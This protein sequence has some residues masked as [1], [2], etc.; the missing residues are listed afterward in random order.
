MSKCLYCHERKGKRPCPALHGAICSQCCGTHRV[1]RIACHS[2]CVYLDTNVA[3]QQQ[4]VGDLFEQER[5]TFYKELL[6]TGGDGA[7]AVFYFLEA[8][9]FKHFQARSDAQDGE[10]MAALQALRRSLSP[11]HVPEGM[12][13]PFTET[14][15]KEYQAFMKGEKHDTQLVSQVLD[16]GLTFIADFSG[17]GLRSNRFLTGLIGFLK[18][19]HPDVAAQLTKLGST[20]GRIILP[21]GATDPTVPSPRG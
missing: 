11:I 2:D 16:R 1:V 15:K 3:Y 7:A 9:T 10:V 4:R 14:L 20:E 8:V 13:P 17:N 21:S 18:S 5:R 12:A 19:R 6:E